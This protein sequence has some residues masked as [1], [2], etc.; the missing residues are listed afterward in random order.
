MRARAC[1]PIRPTR[2]CHAPTAGSPLAHAPPSPRCRRASEARRPAGRGA[3]RDRHRA[4]RDARRDRRTR[5]MPRSRCPRALAR[6]RAYH[7]ASAGCDSPAASQCSASTMASGSPLGVSHSAASLCPSARSA[8]VSI[9]YAASRTSAWLNASSCS[10]ANLAGRAAVDELALLELREPRVGLRRRRRRATRRRPTRTRARRRSPREARDAPR[11][12]AP[13][14]AL[15]TIAS[16]LS[17]SLRRVLRRRRARAPRDRTR[18]P[19][20]DRR[21]ARPR[22]GVARPP[23]ACTT[24]SVAASRGSSPRSTR[25]TSRSAH[26]SGNR[27]VISGPRERDDEE[28][29][30]AKDS[31]R[32]VQERERRAIAPVQIVEDDDERMRRALRADEVLPGESQLVVHDHRVAPRGREPRT[33]SFEASGAPIISARN[34]VTRPALPSAHVPAYAPRE[35]HVRRFAR[36]AGENARRATN[37]LRRQP[38]RRSRAE[39]VAARDPDLRARVPST[40]RAHDLV[41]QARFSDARRR[42]HERRPRARLR[43]CTPRTRS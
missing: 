13:R 40:Q 34:V 27:S 26:R 42:R 36:L 10:P 20:R 8:P 16:A 41:S 28:R 22:S 33:S 39:R 17:G 14:G 43:R 6:R 5:R 29:L 3:A 32:R 7:A 38:E 25:T 35:L 23:S 30:V 4:P 2:R 15:C 9:A 31:K 18:C 11:A 19:P 24:S 21:A 37:E 12:R 1:S